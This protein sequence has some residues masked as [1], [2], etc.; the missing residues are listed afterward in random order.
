MKINHPEW[1]P[2]YLNPTF[3]EIIELSKSGW[4][5][6]RILINDDNDDIII[7]SGLGNTHSSIVERYHIHLGKKRAPQTSPFI[8][9]R[10]EGIVYMNQEDIGGSQYDRID[11]WLI[12]GK[13]LD[14]LR[15]LIRE[16]G[17]AL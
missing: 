8:M 10:S 2:C 4:D 1:Y 16:S 11:K 15:D 13:N 12:E 17:L 6:C 3:D 7:A 14:I 5:T 9:H